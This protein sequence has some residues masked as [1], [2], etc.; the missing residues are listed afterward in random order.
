MELASPKTYAEQA[1]GTSWEVGAQTPFTLFISNAPI[2][3]IYG[4]IEEIKM[5]LCKA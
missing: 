5:N 3:M 4:H 1:R 2:I